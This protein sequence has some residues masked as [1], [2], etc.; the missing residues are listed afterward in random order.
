M[1]LPDDARLLA[2]ANDLVQQLQRIFGEHPVFLLGRRAE[3]S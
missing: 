1:P 2:L 3:P